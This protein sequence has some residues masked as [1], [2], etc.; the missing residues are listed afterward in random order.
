M[1]G[2][3]PC[4]LGTLWEVTWPAFLEKQKELPVCKTGHEPGECLGN[5]LNRLEEK[6]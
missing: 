2:S 4:G 1:F 6:N 3:T 5:R